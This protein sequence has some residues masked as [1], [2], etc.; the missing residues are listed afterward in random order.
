MSAYTI[1]HNHIKK[2]VCDID[3]ANSLYDTVTQ[4]NALEVIDT[5]D[6]AH[7][8]L[9]KFLQAFCPQTYKYDRY[10]ENAAKF[11]KAVR[12]RRNVSKYLDDRSIDVLETLKLF[13]EHDV[14]S[15]CQE[16]GLL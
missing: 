12:L 16:F 8:K 7:A 2:L 13:D 15:V 5:V 14:H 10:N 1:A 6:T 4:A 3:R 11:N 9:R